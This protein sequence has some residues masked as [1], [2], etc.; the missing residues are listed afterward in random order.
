MH[1]KMSMKY[2]WSD[3]EKKNPNYCKKNL[4][5]FHSILHK[6]HTNSARIKPEPPW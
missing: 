3:T 4:S 2:L 1:T 6:L 5:Q